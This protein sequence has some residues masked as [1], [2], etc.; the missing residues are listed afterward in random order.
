MGERRTAVIIII[1]I[2]VILGMITAWT[3]APAGRRPEAR[4]PLEEV[5]D[6]AAIQGSAEISRVGIATSENY[7]GHRI[8]LVGATVKNVSGRPIRMLEVKMVFTDY[9]GNSV[10]EYTDKVLEQTQKPIPPGSDYR[11]E[12]RFENLP[13]NWNY[14]V[15]VTQITKIGY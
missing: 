14:R 11:F 7:V 4:A 5:L 2:A 13:R 3:L 6:V 9:D 8:R 10:H 1:A 15:P 12:M